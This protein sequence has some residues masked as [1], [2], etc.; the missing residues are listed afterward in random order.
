MSR[1]VA[2]V[3]RA[4][5]LGDFLTGL[6]A[7]QLIRRALPEHR[8]VL[9]APAALAPLVDLVPGID[10]LFDRAELQELT[11]FDRPVDIG[12][13][14]HGKGPASRRLL[15]GLGPRRLIGFADPA[16]DL[17]GPEW[18]RDEHEVD[19]WCRLVDEAFGLGL[20]PSDWP[21]VSGSLLTPP[22]VRGTAGTTIVHPGAAAGSRRWPP[23]RFAA[24]AAAVADRGHRVLVSGGEAEVA[25]AQRVAQLGG[26]T[27]RTGSTLSELAWLIAA[28]RVVVCG[29]TGVAHLASA[30]GTPSVL[31]FGPVPPRLW[32]PPAHRRHVVLWHG[33]GTGDPHGEDPDPAL[34]Q[35]TVAEVLDA[36]DQV[37]PAAV[38]RG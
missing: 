4:L 22:A 29:D 24:V 38:P 27:V 14:L 23:E 11:D 18:R 28:A 20:P 8:I 5:G 36:V 1:P 21:R 12:I 2:L 16:A 13:D 3:L 17:A 34:L 30:Y 26:A 10:E 6:P 25:L 37:A 31:L 15:A 35:I 19:R 9:A 32:G 7:L 33:D